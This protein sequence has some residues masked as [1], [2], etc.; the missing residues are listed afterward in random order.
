MK[1]VKSLLLGTAAG[2]VAIAGAQA[3]DLPGKAAPA[4]YVRICDTYGAGFFF[5]PGT[6]TCL[7]IGGF[8]RVDYTVNTTPGSRSGSTAVPGQRV[9]GTSYFDSLY[10]TSAR[11][12]L[13]VDARSNTEYGLLRAFGQFS[14]YRGQFDGAF[15]SQ[16]L[17]NSGCISRRVL[18]PSTSSVPSSSSLASPSASRPRS[19]TST[20]A[21]CSS[22][23][24]SPRPRARPPCW[25]IPPRSVRAS[26]RRCRWK[27]A[28]I[29]ATQQDVWLDAAGVNITP[30]ARPLSGVYGMTYGPRKSGHRRQPARRSGLG[31]GSDHG[32]PAP[33]DRLR[34]CCTTDP[35]RPGLNFGNP[36]NAAGDKFGWAVGAGLR[37]NLDMLARGDV[38]WLQAVY[39]DGALDYAFGTAN[40]GGDRDHLRRG[41]LSGV[42]ALNSSLRDAVVANNLGGVPVVGNASIQ[43]TKAW[44]VAAGF[45]HFWT[46]ALRSSIFGAIPTSTSRL[47]CW[48]LGHQVL[49]RRR[50]HDLVAGS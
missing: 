23:A 4:E 25:P 2:F 45:R 1:T 35:P 3:A 40:Q 11:L 15:S 14:A 8:V 16:G 44:S 32:C 9:L 18:P 28:C 21:T 6:D 22:P 36:T 34:L 7:R 26:R 12:T 31:F 41:N 13:N 47:R 17:V 30:L 42:N 39:A 24:T 33:A 10:G 38:L 5:I 43:T 19:S 27:T 50:Q 29:A 20:R 37:L 46:P 48:P 49:E